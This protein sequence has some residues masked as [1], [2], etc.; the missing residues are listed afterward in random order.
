M[1][2]YLLIIVAAFSLA[3]GIAGCVQGQWGALPFVLAGGALL[4]YA[5]TTKRLK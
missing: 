1:M 2:R 3:G 4:W 5:L